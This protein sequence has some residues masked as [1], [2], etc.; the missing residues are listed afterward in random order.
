M[1]RILAIDDKADNL[2]VLRAMMKMLLPECVLL[3]ALS[4]EE[5]LR[6]A[7]EQHPDTILL[8][9]LMPGMDGYET[10]IRLKADPETASIPVILLTAAENTAAN[11]TAGLKVG[12]DAFLSKPIEEEEL[13]AQVRAML[14]VKESE[15]ALKTKMD[16][17]EDLVEQRTK[18]LKESANRLALTL[19]QTISVLANTVETKDPY[20]AGHQV[21][22]AALAL[23]LGNEL[24]LDPQQLRG[25]HM[26]ARIHDIGKIKIPSE[27]LSKP[28]KIT[29]LE[30]SLIQEHPG[31]GEAI[32]APIVFP[33]PVGRM[34]AQHHERIDGTGYPKGLFGDDILMEAKVIAVADVVE[35]ISSYRPYRPALGIDAALQEIENGIGTKY[36]PDAVRACTALFRE[37]RFEFD[38]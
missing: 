3:Q 18:E 31:V 9:I 29:P 4:G 1:N 38:E 6:I 13:V 25:I 15:T 23:A 32:V 24:R 16:V 17:L 28:G 14:R 12:A 19:D 35:A 10:T 34:I 30:F 2:V 36:D 27:I 33:W 21:R 26:A 22:C 11:R 5:G 37:N 7:K 8:D 20:T